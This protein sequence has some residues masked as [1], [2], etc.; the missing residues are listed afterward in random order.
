MAVRI[1]QAIRHRVRRF[2]NT[3]TR[4]E[5]V[6]WS[7]DHPPSDMRRLAEP[8]EFIAFGWGDANFFAN[9][10]TWADLKWGTALAALSGTG[11][12]AV[13]VEYVATPSGYAGRDL[14]LSGTQYARLVE[15]IRASF[16]RDGHIQERL[17]NTA[18]RPGVTA[19]REG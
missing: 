4:A 8:L 15:Y 13:H 19:E 7:R 3:A 16:A 10:P 12:G 6:D 11:D 2:P 1:Y 14:R 17:W 5:G 9:T 18:G